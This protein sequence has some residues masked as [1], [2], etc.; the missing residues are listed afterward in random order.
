ME[1]R[2]SLIDL[3]RWPRREHYEFFRRYGFPF[4]SITTTIDVTSLCSTLKERA[5]SFTIGLVYM[6]ARAANAIPQFRQRIR[7]DRPVEHEIVHPGLTILCEGD[8]FRFSLL[9]Y[10]EDFNRFA[11]EAAQRMENTRTAESLVPES[12]AE[13]PDRDDMLFIS[14]LPWFSFTGMV[15]PLPLNPLDSVPRLAWG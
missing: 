5:L 11:V 1:K 14:A 6:L 7:E 15:H 3:D 10:V 9:R 13:D 8:I 2:F 12:L 4:F